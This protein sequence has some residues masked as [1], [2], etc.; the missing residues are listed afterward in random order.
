MVRVI[1]GSQEIVIRGNRLAPAGSDTIGRCGY[2]VGVRVHDGANALIAHNQIR[3]FR[4]TAV[5]VDGREGRDVSARIAYNLIRYF[6]TAETPGNRGATGIGI[7]AHTTDEGGPAPGSGFARASIIGNRIRSL[8]S[9]GSLPGD[10]PL[11]RAGI[12]AGDTGRGV[13]VSGNRI[14]HV[15]NGV[16]FFAVGGSIDDNIVEDAR[17]DGIW[18]DGDSH[19]VEVAGNTI[20]RSG[21]DGIAMGYVNGDV[22]GNTALRSGEFDCRDFGFSST[23]S[24]NIGETSDPEGLCTPPS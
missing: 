7:V 19:P 24:N 2:T 1:D 21:S 9:A 12:G 14:R 16:S 22:T 17:Q 6:H 10:T 4:G 13:R 20:L 15:V 11:L 18:A 5:L 3:D 8:T 23:W